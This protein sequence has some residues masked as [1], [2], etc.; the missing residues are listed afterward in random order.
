MAKNITEA[1]GDGR[2]TKG[3]NLAEIKRVI[4]SAASEIIKLETERSAVQ[5]AIREN[6]AKVKGCGIKMAD[7]NAVLRLFKL[8]DEDRAE[9]V[10]NLKICIEA[11]GIAS[12]GD[13]FPEKS[14]SAKAAPVAGNTESRPAA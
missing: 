2:V 11:L 9:S 10:D 13:L 3:H 14:E 5:T 8:E 4:S 6:K 12:Q 1:A 7:F